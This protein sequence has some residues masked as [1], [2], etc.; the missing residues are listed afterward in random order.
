[1]KWLMAVEKVMGRQRSFKEVL[2]SR[3]KFGGD[4]DSYGGWSFFHVEWA[5]RAVERI[6]L[7]RLPFPPDIY[8]GLTWKNY[9]CWLC[10][11]WGT[12][13]QEDAE[14]TLAERKVYDG[15]EKDHCIHDYILDRGVMGVGELGR[16]NLVQ[17]RV[18][19][20]DGLRSMRRLSRPIRY[21]P[22]Q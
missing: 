18:T 21:D 14:R 20:G 7:P 2:G 5:R 11:V 16:S 17:I 6:L 8:C 19:R 15:A 4:W 1:M 12:E 13:R 10:Q 22:E 3:G 9:R